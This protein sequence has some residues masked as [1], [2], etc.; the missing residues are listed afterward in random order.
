MA[1]QHVTLSGLYRFWPENICISP[2]RLHQSHGGRKLHSTVFY[3]TPQIFRVLYAYTHK[4]S[5]NLDHY[6]N[7]ILR[8]FRGF[9]Q[10][11]GNESWNELKALWIFSSY[12]HYFNYIRREILFNT[13]TAKLI[14]TG[15]ARI[16]LLYLK[17]KQ[18][19][20]CLTVWY[21]LIKCYNYEK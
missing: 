3:N 9:I 10:W 2:F 18:L 21:L 14:F 20:N 7:R 19:Q 12:L 11:S 1:H 4:V 8:I 16:I 5:Y 17:Y 15:T 13:F 6:G